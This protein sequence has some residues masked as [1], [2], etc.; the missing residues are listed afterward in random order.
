MRVVFGLFLSNTGSKG[1]TGVIL[2]TM[3]RQ[4]SADEM[5]LTLQDIIPIPRVL[6]FG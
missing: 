4:S 3:L 6:G 1:S 2:K 5:P